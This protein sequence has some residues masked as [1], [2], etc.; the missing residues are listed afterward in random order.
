MFLEPGYHLS[1]TTWENDGD[2]YR[3]TTKRME[4]KEITN[5]VPYLE[6]FRPQRGCSLTN[7]GGQLELGN[8]E[9]PRYDDTESE[10]ATILKDMEEDLGA[11]L[12][13]TLIDEFVGV[14]YYGEMFRVVDKIEVY[15]CHT[16]AIN[17]TNQFVS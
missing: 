17:V 4:K 2:N 9:V 3:T 10:L 11:L 15:Y 6:L 16:P 7:R 12:F 8:Q 13:D 1:V 14:W 5:L